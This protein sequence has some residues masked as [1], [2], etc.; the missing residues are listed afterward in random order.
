[1]LFYLSPFIFRIFLVSLHAAFT[2]P[3]LLATLSPPETDPQILEQCANADEDHLA[4]SFQ[5]MDSGLER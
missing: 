5:Q 4:K 2:G 3:S 1:M